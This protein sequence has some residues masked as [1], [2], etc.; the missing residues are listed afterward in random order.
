MKRVCS[1]FFTIA[2]AACHAGT[3]RDDRGVTHEISGKPTIVTFAHTA[4]T[5]SHFG[6]DRS[7][8]VG[9][10]GEFVHDGS[11]Y[12]FENLQRGSTY[13]ADPTPEEMEFITSVPHISPS[14][15][16]G[17]CQEFDLD[18]F[19]DVKPDYIV[20]HGYRGDLWGFDAD[21]EKQVVNII[22]KPIIYIDVAQQGA[23]C[24]SEKDHESCYGKSMIEVVEQYY[25]LA[26]A[27]GVNIPS[28][29]EQDRLDLCKA[30]ETFQDAAEIAHANGVRAIAGYISV[31]EFRNAT[32]Y[33]AYPPDDMVLR[34]FEE[35]GMPLIHPGICQAEG[36]SQNYFWEWIPT[37]ALFPQC[38]PGQDPVTCDGEV[39]YPA[40]MWLYDHRTTLSFTSPDFRN[41]FPDPAVLRGQYEY[42]PIGGGII[43]FKHAAEILSIMAPALAKMERIHD[44]TPCTAA[45]VS[46][47]EHAQDGLAAGSYACFDR[48]VHRASYLQCPAM[49]KKVSNG[50]IIGICCGVV[51]LLLG[52]ALLYYRKK[53]SVKKENLE[54]GK[55]ESSPEAT[56]NDSTTMPHGLS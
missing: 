37:N 13:P 38:S 12:D 23:N 43:S 1:I 8:L 26:K 55:P 9:V 52:V 41:S 6:L 5:L 40:D 34:M 50:A 56:N 19:R 36:C 24:I 47:I 3:F 45:N 20:M 35:L 15:L 42:W 2:V 22:G 18:I 14:C 7:Q 27:L 39:L 17:Y 48:A 44:R 11:D 49:K 30:A 33:L 4:V 28:S 29:V 10:Y 25:E 54:E 32:S 53:R 21:K 46:S 31:N 16:R 51:G